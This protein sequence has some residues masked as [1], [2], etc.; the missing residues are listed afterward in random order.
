[1]KFAHQLIA[2]LAVTVAVAA[3]GAPG[4]PV[5]ADRIVAVVNNEAITHYELRARL[6]QVERQLAQQK[7]PLPPRDIL[8]RQMLERMITD[9][10]Q[11]QLA[12]ESG[13]RVDDAQLD[14]ALE[15]IAEGNRLGLPQFRAALE[16][17]GI[18]WNKF[19]EEVRKEILVVRV[20][21]REVD[22]R[23]TVSEGEVDNYLSSPE[24]AAGAEEFLIHHILV[25]IPEQ[26][27]PEQ[28]NKLRARA[29]KA[30]AQ[31]KSGV[32]FPQVA[33][34]FSDAPDAL[35]GGS[36][37]WR[38]SDRMPALFAETVAKLQPGDVSPVLRS[39][40]G[41][42][43]LRLDQRRGGAIAGKPV[44]QTHA[45]HILIKVTEIVPD[46]EAKRKLE[47][48]KDRL[49]HGGDF[50]ELAKSQSNDLSAAKGGDL[51]WLYAGDTVPEFERAM[52]ALKPGEISAPIRSPFGWHLIQVLERRNQDAS[53]ERQRL[54]AR[55]AIR[56]RKIEESYQDWVR[57]LRDRAYVEYRLEEK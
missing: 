4:K 35:T 47:V 40:G 15:R 43:V 46:D 38:S 14:K 56:E 32:A 36:L 16:R 30:L 34:S 2:T 28:I 37:G 31:V 42:H 55:Q 51:G 3:H 10:V 22:N 44:L 21:E 50:A 7:T 8:E 25:R 6:A 41:F 45:R 12:N 33:A 49:D 20:R 23:V 29:E 39:A 57:Q 9:R 1:M 27:S 5:A 18:A 11:L 53:A 48:L 13:M 17:D 19:R 52:D 26:A 24:R 54:V